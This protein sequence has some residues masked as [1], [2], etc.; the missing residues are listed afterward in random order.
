MR[1]DSLLPFFAINAACFLAGWLLLRHSKFYRGLLADPGPGRTEMIDGLRGWLAL[2]VFFTHAV[3]MHA[4]FTRGTWDSGMA[5]FYGAAGTVGV[6]LFFMITGFLFWSRALR[7]DGRLEVRTFYLSRVRRL[8]P[9][10]LASVVMALAV[11]AVLS[12]FT[13]RGSPL[14]LA[15]E[16]R[17]WLSF[18][19]MRT[20]SLNGIEDAHYINAVYWTLAYEWMFYLCLPLLALFARGAWFYLLLAVACLFCMKSP[21]TLNFIFGVI[22]AA[23]VER[24]LIGFKLDKHWLTPLPLAAL[25]LAVTS[26]STTGLLPTVLLFVF[27]LFVVHG[28]SLFGLLATGSARLLGGISYS[29]YLVHCVVLYTLVHLAH[30]YEPLQSWSAGAYWALA[31]LAAIAAVLLSAI[32][33]RLIEHPF[34]A[35]KGGLAQPRLRNLLRTVLAAKVFQRSTRGASLP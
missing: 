12:E 18:G 7:C 33:Y 13:L 22:T 25:A 19:F 29:I 21:I 8:A 11:V 6:S 30:G 27:F 5:P 26:P 24:K 28:N 32:T 16:L 31:G 14:E 1:L 35:T 15:R 10:Y 23:V 4:L 17:P 3:T 2:G 9:M 34:L 20:G